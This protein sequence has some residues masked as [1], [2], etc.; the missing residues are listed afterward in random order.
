MKKKTQNNIFEQDGYH[1][2]TSRI[3]AAVII[4]VTLAVFVFIMFGLYRMNIVEIPQFVTDLFVKPQVNVQD[5]T[6]EKDYDDG[7]FIEFIKKAGDGEIGGNVTYIDITEQDFTEL[8][9]SA[10]FISEYTLTQNV[11]YYDANRRQKIYKNKIWV[12]NEK[13]SVEIYDDTDTMIKYILCDGKKVYVKDFAVYD[14][15]HVKSYPISD[16]FSLENQTGLVDIRT[17]FGTDEIA[18][19]TIEFT[20]DEKMNLYT[21]TYGYADIP[22][23]TEKIVVSFDYGIINTAETF[24]NGEIIYRTNIEGKINTEKINDEVFILK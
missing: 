21:I 16:T 12:K 23:L 19:M 11:H 2:R 15:P 22:E 24:Y 5:N 9:A 14:K 3:S 13:Y 20:R 18:D 7:N 1:T 17:L 10:P 8:I 6:P 4:L